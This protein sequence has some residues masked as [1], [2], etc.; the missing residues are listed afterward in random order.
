LPSITEEADVID[1]I[2]SSNPGSMPQKPR[3]D[4]TNVANQGAE[5]PWSKADM[6]RKARIAGLH[7]QS[8][9]FA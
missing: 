5:A 7:V 2:V 6:D 9:G 4:L 1:R 8:S 3:R